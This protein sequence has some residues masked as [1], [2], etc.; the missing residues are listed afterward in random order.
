MVSGDCW[1]VRDWQEHSDY[2]ASRCHVFVGDVCNEQCEMP[3]PDSALDII[4]CIF[5]LSGIQPDK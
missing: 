4:I 2:D 1:L 5:V 3:F